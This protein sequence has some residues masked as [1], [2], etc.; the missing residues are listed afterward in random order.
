[1]SGAVSSSPSDFFQKDEDR[2]R[3]GSGSMVESPVADVTVDHV[4]ALCRCFPPW[5][6]GMT[7]TLLDADASGVLL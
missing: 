2:L 7:F 5:K 3:L 6:K 4:S 1:M